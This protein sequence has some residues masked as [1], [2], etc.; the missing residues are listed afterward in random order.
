MR[1]AN[2]GAVMQDMRGSRLRAGKL[3]DSR[4]TPAELVEHRRQYHDPRQLEHEPCCCLCCDC[5]DQVAEDDQD[6]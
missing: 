4:M 1:I 6:E 3:V 2:A 5:Q